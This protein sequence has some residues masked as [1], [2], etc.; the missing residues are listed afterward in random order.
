MVFETPEARSQRIAPKGAIWIC[1]A[2]GKTADDR[3]G[4][5]GE[6]SYGWDESCMLNA[7]LVDKITHKPMACDVDKRSGSN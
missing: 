1:A 2:C 3:Y 5:E 7:V 4:I 6:H